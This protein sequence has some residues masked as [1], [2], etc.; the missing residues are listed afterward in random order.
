MSDQGSARRNVSKIVID[1]FPT[2][3]FTKRLFTKRE[4]KSS[5]NIVPWILIVEP[6]AQDVRT[7]LITLSP[8]VQLWYCNI[9]TLP[10]IGR[11]FSIVRWSWKVCLHIFI[12][13][14]SVL[15]EKSDKFPV[16]PWR[17]GWSGFLAV[18]VAMQVVC[19]PARKCTVMLI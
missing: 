8:L 13:M 16:L 19:K 5:K 4:I 1:I 9:Y 14:K 11:Q 7:S 15:M 18:F 17:T 6:G 10:C 3:K 12:S 2:L